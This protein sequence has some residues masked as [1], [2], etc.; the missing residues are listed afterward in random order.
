MEPLHLP[1]NI[2]VHF[3]GA[4]VQNHFEAARTMGVS[5]YLYTC[6]PWVSKIVFGKGLAG[7]DECRRVPAYIAKN[8]LHTIQDSGLFTLLFGAL[9]GKADEKIVWKWYDAMVEFTLNHG[10]PVTC[11]EVDCQ[12]LLGVDVAW[13]FRERLRRDLPEKNRIINV[14]HLED[15]QKGLDRLIEYSE[16][17]AVSVP[18]LRYAHKRDYA[19]NV[20]KYIKSRKPSIDIHML[21]CTEMPIAKECRFATS[22]DSTSYTYGVR[23]GYTWYVKDKR[24]IRDFDSEKIRQQYGAVYDEILK[25]NKPLNANALVVEIDYLKRVYEKVL[26]NQDYYKCNPPDLAVL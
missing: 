14:F 25:Y 26:G 19:A 5:Y 22:C 7:N 23:Y 2:K 6:F 20:A 8:S 1:D 21:G 17:I 4:E 11:V 12:R 18:E 16:Y 3:A 15:G 10:Q 9:K 24:H 13:E